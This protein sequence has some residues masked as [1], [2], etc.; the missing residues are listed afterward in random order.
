MR[1]PIPGLHVGK[2]ELHRHVELE[3]VR[4]EDGQGHQDLHQ[5]SQPAT[6]TSQQNQPL[7]KSRPVWDGGSVADPDPG[8]G[9]FLTPRIPDA[10]PKFFKA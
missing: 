8:S 5:H 3:S 10:R 2:E 1:Q 7:T 6:Q 9:A 4:E